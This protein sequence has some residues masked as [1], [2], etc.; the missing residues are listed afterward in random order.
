[1][2]DAGE[3]VRYVRWAVGAGLHP[4]AG[5]TT[6]RVAEDLAARVGWR[7]QVLYSRDTMAERV[8][9]KPRRLA[10]HIRV[11]RELGALAWLVRGSL[12][13]SQ[14]DGEGG[15]AATGTVYAMCVP[16][17]W[18]EAMGRRLEGV[19]Y[20]GTRVIGVTPEG[21]QR[22]V[23]NARVV[24]TRKPISKINCTPSLR[25]STTH[26]AS[27][28]VREIN[29]D[30]AEPQSNES[31]PVENSPRR[32][33]VRRST[34]RP[35]AQLREDIRIAGQVRL[36]ASWTQ[37]IPLRTLAF[38]LRPLIDLGWDEAEIGSELWAWETVWG[39]DDQGFRWRPTNPVGYLR[40]GLSRLLT[41]NLAE[42]QAEQQRYVAPVPN[43]EAAAVFA[44]VRAK[45]GPG[46]RPA[47][48]ITTSSPTVRDWQIRQLIEE[49]L[50][51][52]EMEM[53]FAEWEALAPETP[54]TGCPYEDSLSL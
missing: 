20:Y 10:D 32:R 41:E 31:R 34:G 7:G 13:N 38:T 33:A 11:L 37:R 8:G 30:T 29:Q 51:I 12:K 52:P 1:M 6:I 24:A 28:S 46:E 15:Y 40:T 35:I 23:D 17:V 44:R 47:F 5:T 39:T 48:K 2:T 21:R 26:S 50:R 22:A 18:D 53:S 4:K 16:A 36:R 3:F 49:G 14:R 45:W 42:P 27:P 9:L 25:A 43:A 54:L 19:G